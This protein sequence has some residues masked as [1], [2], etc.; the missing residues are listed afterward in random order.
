[1]R[2]LLCIDD[3]DNIESRGTGEL[4]ELIA[5]EIEDKR[6][7]KCS[8]ITRHQLFI[9]PDVPYTSH[10][11][12]MCFEADI[13]ENYLNDIISFSSDFLK[14][15]SA[16]G[17]DPGLCVAVVDKLTE[18][19]V[20]INFGKKAKKEILTIPEAYELAK[21]L[22]I[23]LSE[24]GGTGQGVIGALA[25]AGLR[26]SGNDGRFKG[27]IKLESKTG[28]E[29][30]N[31]ILSK[32]GF[33]RVKDINGTDLEGDETVLL[34]EVKAVLSE[35]KSTLLVFSKYDENTGRTLW[36]TCTK[37]QIKSF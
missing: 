21:E 19:E 18:P 24:H 16:E 32:T 26:L 9:H 30:V 27:K 31:Y 36:E 1:M 8:G 25:G 2:V 34:G 20:L 4:A 37:Q 6:W 28:M 7:G 11:S 33:D 5:K 13:D 14:N 23:H 35:G 3:T 12:S 22:G 29:N 10:N 15:E 17:S